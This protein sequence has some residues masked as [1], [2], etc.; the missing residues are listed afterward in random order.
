[1]NGFE[2]RYILANVGAFLAFLPLLVLLLPRRVEAVAPADPLTLLSVLLLVGGVTASLANIAAGHWSDRWFAAAG[3]RRGLIAL[4]LGAV[5]ASYVLLATAMSAVALLVALIA[6]QLAFNIMFAPMGVLLADHVPDARKGLVAGGLNMALPIAGF[7]I[8]ALGWLGNRDALWPFALVAVSIAL[9]FLPLLVR[10]PPAPPS[11]ETLAAPLRFDLLRGDFAMAWIARLL[12]QLGAASLLGYL[13]LYVDT[14]ASSAAGFGAGDTS[15]AVGW[16]TFLANLIAIG[17]GLAAGRLS[18]RIRR[19]RQPLI[20]SALLVAAAL[21]CLALAPSW[22]LIIIAYALFTAGLTA[23]LS[24]DSA[25]VAQIVAARAN[26]GAL[27]GLMNLT[28]TLPAIIAPALALAFAQTM[29]EGSSL[30]LLLGLGS[31]A[32]IVSAIA[33]A[34]IRSID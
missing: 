30:R 21:A 22:P 19:R 26:R 17:A 13:F 8:S 33:V 34:R 1:M 32:A 28:N 5:L 2:R 12:V 3:D 27:L 11:N 16:L 25:M 7:G 10:W 18:D 24:V 15:S 31:V 29:L 6:F 20:L 23:F 9:L 14:V 4:G